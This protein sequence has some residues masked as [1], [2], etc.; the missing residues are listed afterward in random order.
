M[1]VRVIVCS[2]RSVTTDAGGQV[3][4]PPFSNERT[5][6]WYWVLDG[7]QTTVMFNK[8]TMEIW[9]NG[10]TLPSTVRNYV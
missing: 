3:P 8:T 9:C 2:A 10:V 1:S 4:P 5:A 7:V 6:V